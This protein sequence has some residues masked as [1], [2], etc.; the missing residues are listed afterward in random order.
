MES[1]DIGLLKVLSSIELEEINKGTATEK[2]RLIVAGYANYA[3]Q[4]FVFFRGNGTSLV[5]PFSMFPPNPVCNPEFDKLEIIDYG[6]TIKLGEYEAA[7]DYVLAELDPEYKAYC[8]A[9]RMTN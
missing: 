5:A 1:K 6:L 2:S 4:Q 3:L 9:N 8:D 7:V